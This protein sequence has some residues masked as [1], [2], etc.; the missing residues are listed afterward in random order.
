MFG[1]MCVGGQMHIKSGH[2]VLES[3]HDPNVDHVSLTVGKKMFAS[4][5]KVIQ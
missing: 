3:F 1:Q 5:S 2:F 4:Q